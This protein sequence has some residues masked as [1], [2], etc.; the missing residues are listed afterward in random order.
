MP[1]SPLPGSATTG[2]VTTGSATTGAAVPPASAGA[3][4]AHIAMLDATDPLAGFRDR[5]ALPEGIT[6]LDGNSLGALPRSTAPRVREV[7]EAEWGTG[8]I[9]SWNA[10]DW[11]RAPQRV[12]AKIARLIGADPHEVIV[13]DS[14]SVNLHKLIVAVLTARGDRRTVLSE[15]G[16]FP[17]D[18]YMV[19]TALAT[20]GGGRRL[21]LTARDALIDQISTD[22]A[23]VVL[24]HVH[25]KTAEL[26]DMAALTAAAHAKGALVL[27]DLSH[28]VGAVPVALGACRA[29]L[30]VG[31]GYKFLNGGPG[32]PA[33]LY[34][35]ARHQEALVSPLGGWM[36]HARPFAFEDRYEPSPGISRFLCGT[37][38][39]V[40]MAALE[41]GVDLHLETDMQAV[42][43]KSQALA[44]LFMHRMQMQCAAYGMTL[45]G[46]APGMPR[47]SHVSF[48]HPE[49]Y[50]IMQALIAR[51][52]IGDFRA[53]DIL[54]FGLTPLYL[55]Y[56]DIAHAVD[57]L[58]DILRTETWR[59]PEY[60][61][62]QAVT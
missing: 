32:A 38:P 15:P 17:T 2:S 36:G 47:G 56:A 27:W 24:T 28:S 43:A 52:V 59:R 39:I 18:L 13:T 29:D 45:V 26:Y 12:G 25:Y 61:I 22:T 40:A 6:Y 42:A 8:L 1:E 33:F 11:I 5:F 48:R 53:P 49:G 9:R 7:I 16:N 4:A 54:R 41:C 51:G 21:V 3:S 10:A 14:T 62:R 20:L 35:A 23:L 44:E 60:Q 55:R 34:V 46:P 31:C 19:E 37:P 57:V 58:E 50:A 30:A